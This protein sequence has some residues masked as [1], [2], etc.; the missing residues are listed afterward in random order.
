MWLAAVRDPGTRAAQRLDQQVRQGT[1]AVHS[2]R[3]R[4]AAGLAA[5]SGCDARADQLR[6]ETRQRVDRPR[7]RPAAATR[8][9][10]VGERMDRSSAANSAAVRPDGG[11]TS[12]ARRGSQP[13]CT[14][15][16]GRSNT[17]IAGSSAYRE[18]AAG[19]TTW[20][21]ATPGRT[22]GSVIHKPPEP[23]SSPQCCREKSSSP[24]CRTGIRFAC[25]LSPAS[26]WVVP[27]GLEVR[28]VIFGRGTGDDDLRGNR[29][30]QHLLG[31]DCRES[32]G[33]HPDDGDC[34]R[35]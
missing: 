1:A 28:D 10:G 7:S 3:R 31:A 18:G 11:R 2:D 15:P 24:R 30:V 23:G 27:G 29:S 22:L 35:G 25:H 8:L 12:T 4:P 26:G 9:V 16:S 19:G 6:D 33:G 34:G 13:T 21:C 14:A 32:G 20:D 5:S 17:G